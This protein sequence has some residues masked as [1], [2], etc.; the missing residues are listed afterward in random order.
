RDLF[1]AHP[2]KSNSWK[3]VGRIDDRVTFTNGE[4]I[5]SLDMERRIRRE[6]EVKDAVVFGIDKLVPG[7][8]IFRANTASNLSDEAYINKIWPAIEDAN[9]LAEGFAQINREMIA[10]LPPTVYVPMT[11]KSS[12]M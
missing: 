9:S 12:I 1:E 4:K 6:A 7:L 10:I 5:L 8:L 2:T 3:Y 11:A